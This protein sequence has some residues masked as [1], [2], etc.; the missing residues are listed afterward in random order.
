M[1]KVLW[2]IQAVLAA[3][4]LFAGGMKLAL[5]AAELAK[6]ATLPIGFL[7]FIG[8][9]EVLGALGL[10]LPGLTGIRRELTALAAVGLVVIM[11]GATLVSASAVPAMV[12]ALA[13][14]VAWGRRPS[15]ALATV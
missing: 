14:A 7:R 5:P 11:A 15:R 1:T 6:Q 2:A 8:V 13:A 9:C 3:L 4:F 12:G 10:V